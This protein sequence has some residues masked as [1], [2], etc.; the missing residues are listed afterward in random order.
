MSDNELKQMMN[1]LIAKEEKRLNK[2]N[3][4]FMDRHNQ[5]MEEAE[6]QIAI[7]EKNLELLEEVKD[8]AYTKRLS[9]KDAINKLLSQ[10]LEDYKKNG[11]KQYVTED[12]IKE[13][14]KGGK[15]SK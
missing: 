1:D 12:T 2:N 10:S 11:G 5:I 8:Y 4:E 14:L 15:A 7:S 6:R 9:M 13:F 3:K